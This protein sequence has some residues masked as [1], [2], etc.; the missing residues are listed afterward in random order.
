MTAARRVVA[1]VLAAGSATRFG[2]DKLLHSLNGRPL[3]GHIA[4]T[5]EGMPLAARLAVCPADNAARRELFVRHGF[6]VIDN[7]H[8]EQGMGRSLALGAVRAIE[9]DADALLVCLADMPFVTAAHL[10][11]LLSVDAQVVATEAA[12]VRSPP[13]VF[14]RSILP[15]LV[16]LTGDHGARHLLKSAAT[17]VAA[18]QLVR[19]FDTQGDFG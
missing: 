4:L 15:E 7:R 12:A 3:A 18:F 8:P 13:V 17:V 16:T 11:A 10:N 14:A 2:S 6:E 19:D 9:R 5:L 1:L